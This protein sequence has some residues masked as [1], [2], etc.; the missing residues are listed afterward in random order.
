MISPNRETNISLVLHK[1]ADGKM[2]SDVHITEYNA[3]GE[4]G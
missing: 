2:P 4:S 3:R 1:I